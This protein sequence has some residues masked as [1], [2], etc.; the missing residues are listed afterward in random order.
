MSG[1]TVAIHSHDFVTDKFDAA[2][3]RSLIIHTYRIPDPL[4][5]FQELFSVDGIMP[6]HRL[7]R[8]FR[9][10]RNPLGAA[11]HTSPACTQNQRSGGLGLVVSWNTGVSELQL[12]REIPAGG[13][14][15]LRSGKYKGEGVSGSRNHGHAP[16]LQ[17]GAGQCTA[18]LL[19]ADLSFS[20]YG[21]HR[22]L[23]GKAQHMVQRLTELCGIHTCAKDAHAAF[24][25]ACFWIER[26]LTDFV[27]NVVCCT[28]LRPMTR[29][30]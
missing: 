11:F 7:F 22:P 8:K 23:S 29:M 10:V 15:A 20:Q 21:E 19:K 28:V 5:S 25:L 9:K 14:D 2:P 6:V 4:E 18:P 13:H 30:L 1:A 12:S 3:G 24:L 27:E 26:M 16:L 17:V